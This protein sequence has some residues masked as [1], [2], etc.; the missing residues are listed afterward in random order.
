MSRSMTMIES[1]AASR[2]AFVFEKLRANATSHATDS[3]MSRE[4]KTSLDGGPSPS[5]TERPRISNVTM[6]PSR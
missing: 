1:G 5:R 4:M 2:I 6:W 3:V